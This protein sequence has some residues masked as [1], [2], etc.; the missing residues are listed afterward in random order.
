MLVGWTGAG[1]RLYELAPLLRAP[2]APELFAGFAAAASALVAAFSVWRIHTGRLLP[3]LPRL[4]STRWPRRRRRSPRSRYAVRLA[5]ADI[6]L[7]YAALAGALAACLATLTGQARRDVDAVTP[8]ARKL[9][10][11][12]FA[13]AALGGLALGCVCALDRG[14]LTVALAL[15]R[16]GRRLAVGS[17]GSWRCAGARRRW[18]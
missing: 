2:D 9:P 3:A 14:M 7:P 6:A 13:T 17:M 10:L 5:H 12:A 18:R 15:T 16:L 4:A 1:P 11:G 8:L